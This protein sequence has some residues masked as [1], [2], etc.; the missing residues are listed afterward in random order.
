M[1]LGTTS[2]R[3]RLGVGPAV[4]V[5][6]R[7]NLISTRFQP[8]GP[9]PT[10]IFPNRFNGFMRGPRPQTK[11]VENGFGVAHHPTKVRR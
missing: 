10:R 4:F 2:V 3:T 8:G 5:G 1:V 6:I 7:S 9:E 11:T